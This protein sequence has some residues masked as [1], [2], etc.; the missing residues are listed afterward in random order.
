MILADGPTGNLDLET[1]QKM[2]QLLLNIARETNTSV[3]IIK[4]DLIIIKNCPA[5]IVKCKNGRLLNHLTY[6]S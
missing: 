4:H 3:L 5:R 2:L 1:S 6:T